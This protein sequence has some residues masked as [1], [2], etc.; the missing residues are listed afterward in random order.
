MYELFVKRF[1]NAVVAGV[2]ARERG[3]RTDKFS[4]EYIAAFDAACAAGG[5]AGREA[6]TSLFTHD[7]VNVRVTAAAFLLR[8]AE[9]RARAVLT[10][11]AKGRGLVAFEASQALQRWEEGEWELDP[12]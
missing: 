11:A 10:A 4:K 5:D 1:A 9:E 8:Y 2:E 7:D 6:L 12:G 3:A